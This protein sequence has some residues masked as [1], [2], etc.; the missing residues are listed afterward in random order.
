MPVHRIE[1][2]A[3]AQGPAREQY[4]AGVPMD[5]IARS[6][7]ISR[8][9]LLRRIKE[10]GWPQRHPY[11]RIAPAP[12]KLS[13]PPPV[14]SAPGGMTPAMLAGRVQDAVERELAAVER[15]LGKLGP[16]KLDEVECGARTLATL[17]RTLREL[18]QLRPAGSSPRGGA[19]DEPEIR[20]LD[21]FRRDLARRLDR[22]V[23]EARALPPEP[24]E[25]S[26][27]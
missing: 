20:D 11:A 23:A 7:G 4:D 15:I 13:A 8:S 17:A 25:E 14:A 3:E 24:P 12:L 26:G 19:D 5:V 2:A 21:E 16:A 18:T 9:T 1:I 6:L 22:L 27:S 10:L